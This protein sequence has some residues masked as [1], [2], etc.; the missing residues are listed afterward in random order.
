M[1]PVPANY[2]A[3]RARLA[4]CV[5]DLV[6]VCHSHWVIMTIMPGHTSLYIWLLELQSHLIS[7]ETPVFRH[8]NMSK[9][10]IWSP[11]SCQERIFTPE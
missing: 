6:C 1:V 11:G 9:Y 2:V 4:L 10:N 5:S 3:G 8:P 7:R